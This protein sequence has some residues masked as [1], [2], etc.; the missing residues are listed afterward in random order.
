MTSMLDHG[1]YS[2][3]NLFSWAMVT[4]ICLQNKPC[5]VFLFCENN[6]SLT[7]TQ[8]ILWQPGLQE[9]VSSARANF[10]NKS[11]AFTFKLWNN[12]NYIWSLS[13]SEF[14]EPV[15]L[16]RVVDIP[17]VSYNEAFAQLLKFMLMNACRASRWA[18]GSG[19]QKGQVIIWNLQSP[20]GRVQVMMEMEL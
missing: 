18:G 7:P 6:L 13:L 10:K 16:P 9:T 17:L 3:L 2:H 19:H 20:L 4:H 8:Q 15:G 14:L 5:L 1:I 11:D 12:M